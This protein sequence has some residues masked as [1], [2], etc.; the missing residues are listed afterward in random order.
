MERHEAGKQI[1]S[2]KLWVIFINASEICQVKKRRLSKM[3]QLIS[4]YLMLVNTSKIVAMMIRRFSRIKII[5][6]QTL[7]RISEA[8]TVIHLKQEWAKFFDA[9]RICK[10]NQHRFSKMTQIFSQYL[11][12]VNTLKIIEMNMRRLYNITIIF[13]LT[14]PRTT[15]DDPRR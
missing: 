11:L 14:L 6:P 9:S 8:S 4:Q 13:S 12:L 2:K 3:A 15:E 5:I 1:N 7:R 10:Q